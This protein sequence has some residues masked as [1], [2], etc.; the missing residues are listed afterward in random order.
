VIS[1]IAR[2]CE[3]PPADTHARPHDDRNQNAGN[4]NTPDAIKSNIEDNLG[5]IGV[6]ISWI[7][8]GEYHSWG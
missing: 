7:D 2:A 4:T 1:G 5:T 6:L 3:H 8:D